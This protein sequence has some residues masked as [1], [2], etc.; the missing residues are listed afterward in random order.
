MSFSGSSNNGSVR[1]GSSSNNE[2]NGRLGQLSMNSGNQELSEAMAVPPI[3]KLKPPPGKEVP[4]PSE[5]LPPVPPAPPPP[6][7]GPAPP[8]PPPKLARLPPAP[9]KALPGKSPSN[10]PKPQ[11]SAHSSLDE[12]SESGSQKAKLKPF[13]WDKTVLTNTDQSMVWNEIRSG[14]FQ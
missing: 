8:P 7:P 10:A 11:H 9:P 5:L 12:D 4:S 2:F 13:F 3:T 6:P 1:M 14:S